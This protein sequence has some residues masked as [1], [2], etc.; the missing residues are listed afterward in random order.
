MRSFSEIRIGLEG[1]SSVIV[2]REL[3]V[4]HFFP[5]MPEVYST[6]MMIYLMELAAGSAIAKLL[7]DG[8]MSVGTEVRVKHL[9]STPI[10]DTVTALATI[11]DIVN[12]AIVFR[13]EAHDSI[14]KIGE[15][16]HVRVAMSLSGFARRLARRRS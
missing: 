13:V 2:T 14:R 5:S 12:R 7:P 10:G 15:G 4:A 16:T 9:A 1:T 3:T 11:I 8:W 6:P